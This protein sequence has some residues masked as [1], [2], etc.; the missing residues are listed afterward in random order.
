MSRAKAAVS[1]A[2]VAATLAGTWWFLRRYAGG[3]RLGRRVV[4]YGDAVAI[5]SRR[6]RV[7]WRS[8][9]HQLRE[10]RTDPELDLLRQRDDFKKLLADVEEKV[11]S[12]E[13]MEAAGKVK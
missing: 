5:G 8:Q 1:A 9:W 3:G 11:K 2:L 4:G 10:L 13:K 12:R 7:R 6:H